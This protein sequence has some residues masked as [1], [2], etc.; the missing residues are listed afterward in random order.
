MKERAAM[1][2]NRCTLTFITTLPSMDCG[3]PTPT[4]T[5]LGE[6][7]RR[8]QACI[9]PFLPMCQVHFA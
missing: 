2:I 3:T 9:N 4:Y 6:V 1:A 7:Y 5:H 8:E